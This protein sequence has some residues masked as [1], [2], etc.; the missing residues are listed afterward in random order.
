MTLGDEM[1]EQT[2]LRP[3][4]PIETE[5]FNRCVDNVAASLIGCFMFVEDNEGRVGGQ[6]IETE[7]YCQN[8]SAAHCYNDKRAQKGEPPQRSPSKWF[9]SM[10]KPGGHVYIYDRKYFHLNFVCGAKGFG[11]GV[12]IRAL[13]PTCGIPKMF[14][15]RPKPKNNAVGDETYLCSGPIKLCEALRITHDDCDGRPISDTLLRLYR[16]YG[17]VAVSVACGPR[18]LGKL[19]ESSPSQAAISWPRG[20]ILAD[21]AVAKFLSPNARTI[22]G[23]EPYS[24][25]IVHYL[26]TGGALANCNCSP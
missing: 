1:G 5:F 25:D 13:K 20:Y 15:R 6:I 4:D 23:R 22:K 14:D 16:P 9:D 26:K 7:A 17:G 11:S 12:L 18:V 8:D 3:G 2:Q 19:A 24:P 10:Y 21:D